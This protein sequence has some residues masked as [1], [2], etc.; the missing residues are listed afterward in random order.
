MTY[1]FEI[2]NATQAGLGCN[3]WNEAIASLS[4]NGYDPVPEAKTMSTFPELLSIICRAHLD[5]AAAILLATSGLAGAQP[6]PGKWTAGTFSC[7]TETSYTLLA[8]ERRPFP[9]LT[10]GGTVADD[11]PVPQFKVEPVSMSASACYRQMMLTA[12]L[13]L[14]KHD[15]VRYTFCAALSA[16]NWGLSGNPIRARRPFPLSARS[17][18]SPTFLR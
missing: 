16:L 13:F 5:F 1:P 10:G 12:P 11:P 15:F 6:T 17:R 14:R 7:R 9:G 4:P 3:S 2:G 18:P 8:S